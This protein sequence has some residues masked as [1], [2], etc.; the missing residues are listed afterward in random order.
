MFKRLQLSLFL[1][2]L[3]VDLFT[4]LFKGF[5]VLL[6]VD[7][8]DR[9]IDSIVKAINST[10]KDGYSTFKDLVLLF[11]NAKLSSETATRLL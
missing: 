1:L 11:R 7:F 2:I 8:N 9:P 10:F 6:L 5:N 3:E 4:R